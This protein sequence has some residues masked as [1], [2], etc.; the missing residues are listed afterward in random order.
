[1]SLLLENDA[2]PDEAAVDDG[3]TPLWLSARSG[4]PR[5]VELLLKHGADH[6]KAVTVDAVGVQRLSEEAEAAAA[7]AEAVPEAAEL[8]S[9]P[10]T[11]ADGR[12]EIDRSLLSTL[13][14]MYSNEMGSLL[15]AKKGDTPLIAAVQS[16]RGDIARILLEADAD[17]NQKGSEVRDVPLLLADQLDAH[18]CVA[19]LEEYI[20]KS[21]QNLGC[22]EGVDDDVDSVD[23]VDA[24]PRE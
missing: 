5:V 22:P 19:V 10:T 1:M 14:Q 11:P 8:T 13:T 12:A 21:T 7:R 24:A 23:G 4:L 2:D 18:E 9:E 17:P 15:E 3:L 20:A 6:S 16:D